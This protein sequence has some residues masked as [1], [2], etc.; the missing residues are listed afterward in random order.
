ME[1]ERRLVERAMRGDHEAFAALAASRVD[2][3]HATATLILR[4][5]TAAEDAVQEVLVRMWQGL[6][7]LRDPGR[8]DAW[9]H[10]LLAHACTDAWRTRRRRAEIR[11]LPSHERP[12]PDETGGV[13]DREVLGRAFRRLSVEHR[14]VLVLRHYLRLTVPGVADAAGVPVGTAKSRLH[15]A[16]RALRAAIEADARSDGRND[17]GR[18]A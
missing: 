10:R 2:P 6:P 13:A 5:R 3:L 11:L 7:K 15:H 18:L 1:H 9:L 4:D 12:I 16:E 8:L 17:R 14:V